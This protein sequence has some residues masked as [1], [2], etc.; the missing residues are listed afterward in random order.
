[1]GRHGLCLLLLLHLVL[2]MMRLINSYRILV[3][4]HVTGN[5]SFR[6]GL[7]GTGVMCLA[8]LAG[9]SIRGTPV[10]FELSQGCN[11]M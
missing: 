1:V 10:L 4:P 3:F 5:R 11:A 6:G 7:D 8:P 2:T 9:K